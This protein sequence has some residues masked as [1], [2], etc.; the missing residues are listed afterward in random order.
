M[1]IHGIIPPVATPMEANEDL[2]LP[3]LRSFLDRLMAQGIHGV[4]ILGSNGEF[5]SLS[6]YEKQQVIAV[7]VA[8]VRK[9]IPIFAGTGAE[10][11]GEV[12]RLTRMAE[13]E[14]VD[15]VSV[16]T[17]YYVS[18]TQE[19]IYDHYRRIAESTSLPIL[20]YNNPGMTGGVKIDP[21][22]MG[23]LASMPNIMGIKDSSGDLQN[24]IEYLRIGPERFAVFQGR[25]SL[26]LPSLMFG[27]S[28][29]VPASANV[30]AGLCVELYELF[31]RGDIEAAKA[32]QLKLNPIRLSLVKG[33]SPAGV[34]AALKLIG[35][36]I[37]PSRSPVG[38]IEPG[39]HESMQ[40]ALMAAG[41]P[42]EGDSASSRSLS[43]PVEND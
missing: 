3:R 1:E 28:G 25:D 41:I 38:A 12:V 16:I 4:F 24:T 34:K 15:G 35:F 6:E 20:L 5:F 39:D 2:D 8:Q 14:G 27:A 11:T 30:A 29:A 7:T 42:N 26:I 31:R 37:G 22:T 33:T 17:P 32:A 19:E 21:V 40:R 43:E 9:R 23:R 10:S 18:P 36:P 13:R